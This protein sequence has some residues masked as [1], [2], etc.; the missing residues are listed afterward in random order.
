MITNCLEVEA[1]SYINPENGKIEKEQPFYMASHMLYHGLFYLQLQHIIPK[2]QK[3]TCILICM[4][5][6]RTGAG[7]VVI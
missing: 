3:N 1:G 2:Y 6:N 7:I 4:K 5:R